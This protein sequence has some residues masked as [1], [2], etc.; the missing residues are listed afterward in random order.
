MNMSLGDLGAPP[1]LATRGSVAGDM[2]VGRGRSQRAT[3]GEAE[4]GTRCQGRTL[5]SPGSGL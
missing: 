3:R 1:H 5:G 2:S 4:E